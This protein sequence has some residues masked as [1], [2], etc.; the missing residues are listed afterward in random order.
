MRP[1]TTDISAIVTVN[2]DNTQ[3]VYHAPSLRIC[4]S[5]RIGITRRD[6]RV[7]EQRHHA[8]RHDQREAH[9]QI[10]QRGSG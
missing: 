6:D 8:Q 5:S 3:P 7:D 1:I 10:H 2:A 4:C 9:A